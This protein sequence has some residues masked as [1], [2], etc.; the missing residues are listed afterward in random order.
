MELEE[1]KN[2]LFTYINID[3][4]DFY[5]EFIYNE[6]NN[7]INLEL[8]YELIQKLEDNEINEFTLENIE[9]KNKLYKYIDSL[10]YFLKK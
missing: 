10:I 7:K 9:E 8:I 3:N 5:K 2:K 1:L 4:I 6:E